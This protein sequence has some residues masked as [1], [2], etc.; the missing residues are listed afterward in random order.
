MEH[1]GQS[2]DEETGRIIRAVM[3]KAQAKV[4]RTEMKEV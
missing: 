3:G 4:I 1:S 2:Q